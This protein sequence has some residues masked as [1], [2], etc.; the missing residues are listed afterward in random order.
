MVQ[1]I[2]KLPCLGTLSGPSTQ[3]ARSCNW[4]LYGAT[5]SCQGGSV[6]RSCT[7]RGGA[8]FGGSLWVWY[9]LGDV[10][11]CIW[12]RFCKSYDEYTIFLGF[13]SSWF[14]DVLWVFIFVGYEPCKLLRDSLSFVLSGW[15]N[16]MGEGLCQIRKVTWAVMP[17]QTGLWFLNILEK[18]RI[19]VQLAFP[20]WWNSIRHF[21]I[22]QQSGTTPKLHLIATYLEGLEEHRRACPA[23][24]CC[25]TCRMDPSRQQMH[26]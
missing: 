23:F 15:F 19:S 18:F 26:R 4:D 25:D 6:D 13:R 17:L 20:A 21:L 3:L 2:L 8:K 11:P 9:D 12:G 16:S 7:V 10:H 14:Y 1:P 24:H 22:K 5:G